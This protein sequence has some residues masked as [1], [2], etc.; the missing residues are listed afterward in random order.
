MI[1]TEQ[2]LVY[3]VELVLDARVHEQV[4]DSNDRTTDQLRVLL[5]QQFDGATREVPQSALEL[6]ALLVVESS[7]RGDTRHSPTARFGGELC[8][9]IERTD[10]IAGP[11]V[12]ARPTQA[13]GRRRSEAVEQVGY[14]SPAI[15]DRTARVRQRGTQCIARF[16]GSRETEQ[17]VFYLFDVGDRGLVLEY[18]RRVPGSESARA[19]AAEEGLSGLEL[20]GPELEELIRELGD[21]AEHRQQVVG[22]DSGHRPRHDA[23]RRSDDSLREEIDHDSSTRVL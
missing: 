1:R 19:D 21:L 10:R 2:L 8:H 9:P 4:P 17:F 18:G 6:V 12:Q 15:L 23:H 13:V 16:H 11:S 3:L 14:E 20:L 22:V 7:S 5:D